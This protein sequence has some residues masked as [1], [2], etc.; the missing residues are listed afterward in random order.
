MSQNRPTMDVGAYER[1]EP[2][3]IPH[4]SSLFKNS[5]RNCQA[6]G[7][8]KPNSSIVCFPPH[9]APALRM[10]SNATAVCMAGACVCSQSWLPNPVTIDSTSNLSIMLVRCEIKQTNKT[11]ASHLHIQ[12]VVR[13][14]ELMHHLVFR[15]LQWSRLILKHTISDGRIVTSLTIYILLLQR[16]KDLSCFMKLCDRNMLLRFQK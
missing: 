14:I 6:F 12:S 3:W 9:I 1:K 10:R 8:L 5:S 15:S 2:E 13:S 7:Y 11:T 4:C 16:C